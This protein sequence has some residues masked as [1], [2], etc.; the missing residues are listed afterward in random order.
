MK[1]PEP[2]WYRPLNSLSMRGR[3]GVGGG[4]SAD[5]DRWKYISPNITFVAP[6]FLIVIGK[7]T[8][9]EIK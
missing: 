6:L 1:V 4:K 3:V 2:E 8:G 7:I 9:K 5:Y